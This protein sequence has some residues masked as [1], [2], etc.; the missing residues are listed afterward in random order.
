MANIQIRDVPENIHRTL[1]ARAAAQGK[2]LSDYLREEV[3]RIAEHPTLEEIF[4]HANTHGTV[5]LDEI[6]AA[7]RSGRDRDRE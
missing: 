6:V 7:V 2:S 4:A 5:P 1:K 3:T